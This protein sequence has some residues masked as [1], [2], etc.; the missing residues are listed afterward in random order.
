[1]CES[2]FS[3]KELR[4]NGCGFDK[5]KKILKKPSS[6]GDIDREH[7]PEPRDTRDGRCSD[8]VQ[9]HRIERT[10]FPNSNCNM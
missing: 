6:R 4:T 5:K 1:M 2:D 8:V 3:I 10:F 9:P 7:T